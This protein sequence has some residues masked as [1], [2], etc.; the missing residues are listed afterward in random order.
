MQH[1]RPVDAWQAT[2]DAT[3]STVQIPAHA[4]HNIA[5]RAQSH[6][7]HLELGGTEFSS[8]SSHFDGFEL[9][10]GKPPPE[11]PGKPPLPLPMTKEENKKL[12]KRAHGELGLKISEL[13]D[14]EV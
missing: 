7:K 10:P 6:G 1:I 11:L 2:R 3:P 13:C 8:N 12:L 4:W 9:L 14:M 5:K